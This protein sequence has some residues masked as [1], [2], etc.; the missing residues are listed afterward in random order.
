[1]RQSFKPGP[2]LV[3]KGEPETEV[4]A[5]LEPIFFQ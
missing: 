3:A 5:P 4:R 2:A 1:M